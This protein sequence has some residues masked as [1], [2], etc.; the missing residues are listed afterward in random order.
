M[1]SDRISRI[2]HAM[3]TALEPLA[4]SNHEML[5]VFAA[6][7]AA[8]GTVAGV[9]A[10]VDREE[11]GRQAIEASGVPVISLVAASQIFRALEA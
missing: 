2:T 7:R 10:L 1:T 9:L 3:A 4:V 6:V 5:D 8:N 11:G